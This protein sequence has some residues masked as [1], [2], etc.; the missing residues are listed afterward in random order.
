MP[1][2]LLVAMNKLAV[3]SVYL[4]FIGWTLFRHTIYAILLLF[5]MATVN[6]NWHRSNGQ[7]CFVYS[8]HSLCQCRW[9]V[10]KWLWK[11]SGCGRCWMY[12]WSPGSGSN[13][14]D[15]NIAVDCV[16]TKEYTICRPQG[17]PLWGNDTDSNFQSELFIWGFCKSTVDTCLKQWHSTERILLESK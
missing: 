13:S 17:E 7:T 2:R 16:V 10:I 5:Q 12:P 4:F 15:E 14:Y 11:F 6:S 9:W 8:L 1:L 3:N